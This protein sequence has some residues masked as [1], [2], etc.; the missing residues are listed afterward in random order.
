[1]SIR[2]PIP[3][4][5]SRHHM[6]FLHGPAF[7]KTVQKF[8]DIAGDKGDEMNVLIRYEICGFLGDGTANQ[9]INFKGLQGIDKVYRRFRVKGCI[10]LPGNLPAVNLGHQQGP[11]GIKNR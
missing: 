5:K 11:G 2:I 10:K 4:G 1:M 8:A 9:G 7:D 3:G 6:L